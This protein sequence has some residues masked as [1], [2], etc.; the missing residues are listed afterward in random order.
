VSP[1]VPVPLNAD[2]KRYFCV[3]PIEKYVE[4]PVPAG[5]SRLTKSVPPVVFTQVKLAMNDVPI[6]ESVLTS[7]NA[8]TIFVVEAMEANDV[9]LPPD[10]IVIEYNF[11]INSSDFTLLK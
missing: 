11:T 3:P 6:A 5:I 1:D 7:N 4:T 8:G 9:V 10:D 2:I